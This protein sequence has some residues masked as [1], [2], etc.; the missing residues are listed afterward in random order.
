MT[1]I[2]LSKTKTVETLDEHCDLVFKIGKVALIKHTEL[3]SDF[4]ILA[5]L[6]DI[7]KREFRFRNNQWLHS[8]VTPEMLIKEKLDLN[9]PRA[10][11]F[12]QVINMHHGSVPA[13]V[14][15]LEKLSQKAYANPRIGEIFWGALGYADR[16]A[17]ALTEN[18]VGISEGDKEWYADVEHLVK[19][20]GLQ[21]EFCAIILDRNIFNMSANLWARTGYGII[22]AQIMEEITEALINKGAEPLCYL[23]DRTIYA[24]KP[25]ISI[26]TKAIA[27]NVYEGILELFNISKTLSRGQIPHLSMCTKE[28]LKKYLNDAYSIILN[29]WKGIDRTKK[30]ASDQEYRIYRRFLTLV[31]TIAGAIEI[32]DFVPGFISGSSSGFKIDISS[33]QKRG[34]IE[35]FMMDTGLEQLYSETLKFIQTSKVFDVP[36]K[37]KSV[38]ADF[39]AQAV[40]LSVGSL[41]D[42]FNKNHCGIIPRNKS[43][44]ET[45]DFCG[46]YPPVVGKKRIS[47][48]KAKEAFAGGGVKTYLQDKLL[49]EE[50]KVCAICNFAMLSSIVKGFDISGNDSYLVAFQGF[51]KPVGEL[52]IEEHANQKVLA[53]IQ[54]SI[55]FINT[56]N[57]NQSRFE[58]CRRVED[59]TGKYFLRL[60]DELEEA[61]TPKQKR[62]VY[63]KTEAESLKAMKSI[64]RPMFEELIA[65]S[66]ELDKFVKIDL[67]YSRNFFIYIV[68]VP[69]KI[70]RNDII[71]EDQYTDAL[72]VLSWLT[73]ITAQKVQIAQGI[74]KAVI[75][76]VFADFIYTRDRVN[77]DSDILELQPDKV[78][79]K[80][81]GLKFCLS[82]HD[83]VRA[84][85]LALSFR[86][87]LYSC[88]GD[89]KVKLYYDLRR[90]DTLREF[91]SK[92]KY[93]AL[94]RNLNRRLADKEKAE[95]KQELIYAF[96]GCQKFLEELSQ[97]GEL[98]NIVLLKSKIKQGGDLMYQEVLDFTKKFVDL[99][100]ALW[101]LRTN[102][103]SMTELEEYPRLLCRGVV[104]NKD[105]K[106]GLISAVDKIIYD[107]KKENL[108]SSDSKK[109]KYD[110]DAIVNFKI[111]VDEWIKNRNDSAI[112]ETI[113]KVP[114]VFLYEAV[115]RFPII[116]ERMKKAA[117]N[118]GK[119]KEAQ[120]EGKA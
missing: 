79:L 34:D 6:H 74:W 57:I 12:S 118:R 83:I 117:D 87:F 50:K 81:F 119:N 69:R 16:L 14:F 23:V 97:Y 28:T 112:R 91:E 29:Q 22:A 53:R 9:L 73:K 93:D 20:H 114:R 71:V 105:A 85:N 51:E 65:D 19:E 99:L 95:L 37:H 80:T 78:I 111:F 60:E 116:K 115:S 15:A 103:K 2:N 62:E 58:Q 59:E 45:C 64:M 17:S 47:L 77:W 36:V 120:K 106:F 13:D 10:E 84:S 41:E 108:D 76:S 92:I 56:L 46:F 21:I 27:E 35:K 67:V 100:D 39:I 8:S 33:I 38:V 11:L 42:V 31:N 63:Q 96:N 55:T 49:A 43:G 26:D 89:M 82:P 52:V 110:E 70:G 107:V 44:T 75:P 98:L 4:K 109:S 61:K 24:I 113:S 40:S 72:K 18:L 5:A 7:R 1:E 66:A 3:V 102:P 94:R 101:L 54:K 90:S 88:E 25:D 32:S 68:K 104:K 86:K 48:E 30:I